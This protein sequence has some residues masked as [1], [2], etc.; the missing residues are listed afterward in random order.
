M[1]WRLRF[2]DNDGVE[3]GYAEKPDRDT[4]NVVITHP[5]SGW[6]EFRER[7]ESREIVFPEKDFFQTP[8]DVKID[9]GPMINRL[10]PENHLKQVRE[11]FSDPRIGSTELS[12]E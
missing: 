8:P 7:L 9:T 12:D 1:V 11:N 4:Y 2:Y 3:I 6:E 10:N 5:D